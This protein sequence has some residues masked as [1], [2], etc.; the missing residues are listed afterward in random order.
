MKVNGLLPTPAGLPMGKE[1]LVPLDTW[2]GGP[3]SRSGFYAGEKSVPLLGIEPQSSIALLVTS[4]SAIPESYF[5]KDGQISNGMLF[6]PSLTKTVQL[7][8]II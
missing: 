2:L 5:H 7:V 6:M 4:D 8:S 1:P 3:L